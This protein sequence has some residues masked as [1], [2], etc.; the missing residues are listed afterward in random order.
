[1][2]KY[3]CPPTGAHP[4]ELPDYWKFS[5]GVVRRDLQTLSDTE[6]NLWGWEGPFIYP[7]AKITI[8][9]S[10]LSEEGINELVAD[11][12]Y[13]FND[14]TNTFTSVQFD[15]DP[16]THNL[17]WYS[18][19]RKFIILPKDEDT[20]EYDI[21]YKSGVTPPS[22]FPNIET[23]P[24]Q[25]SQPTETLPTPPPVLWGKFKQYLLTSVELN[26]YIAS[27]YQIMPIVASSFPVA[28]SR[29][30]YGLYEDFILIWNAI[31][32]DNQISPELITE[33]INMAL[34]CNL[35]QEFITI[36]EN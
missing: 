16:K 31:N 12:N 36:L 22:L 33:I 28:I 18:K 15:Y 17:V 3:Y 8:E 21:K 11:E 29:L 23:P 6:L 9:A 10:Y 32:K 30:E 20:T 35:H 25:P 27:L 1:M 5:N 14:E 19:E 13:I 2:T 26:Q 24:F 4:Q 34:E 7:I